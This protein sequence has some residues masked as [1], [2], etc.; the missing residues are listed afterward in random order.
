MT[1][2]KGTSCLRDHKTSGGAFSKIT[3]SGLGR[4]AVISFKNQ[5]GPPSHAFRINKNV[6]KIS[7]KHNQSSAHHRRP[8]PSSKTSTIVKGQISHLR[9]RSNTTTCWFAVRIGNR[10]TGFCTPRQHS[11]PHVKTCDLRKCRSELP[12]NCFN[13]RRLAATIRPN[14]RDTAARG[15]NDA[16]QRVPQ[17]LQI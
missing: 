3:S 4:T 12:D 5:R 8:N 14:E 13:H 10:S 6:V 9:G 16:V 1:S 15:M 7:V 17:V 11:R 2:S